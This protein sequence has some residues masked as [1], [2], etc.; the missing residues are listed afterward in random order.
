[1]GEI[2]CRSNIGPRPFYTTPPKNPQ[3]FSGWV[4]YLLKYYNSK[5]RKSLVSEESKIP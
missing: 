1:M 3:I 4:V 2:Y 5:K